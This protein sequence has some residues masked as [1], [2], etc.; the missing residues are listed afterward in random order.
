MAEKYF[1]ILITD[2]DITLDV[3]GLPE[4]CWDRDSIAQD[5]KHMIRDSGLLVELVANRDEGKKAENLV[6][7]TIMVDDDER[8]VPGS[9]EIT[10]VDLGIFFLEAETVEFGSV[11]LTMEAA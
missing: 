8:I 6:E 7:L 1:D 2:D 11:S 3:G 5:I 10:E 4:R 9:C